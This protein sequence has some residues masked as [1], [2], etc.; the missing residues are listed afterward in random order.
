MVIEQ[1]IRVPGEARFSAAQRGVV[2]LDN[3]GIATGMELIF[4]SNETG[5]LAAAT[6]FREALDVIIAVASDR[7]ADQ[8]ARFDFEE[9]Q[10]AL[11]T[12]ERVLELGESAE[13]VR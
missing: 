12:Q 10:R 5:A 11:A 7:L 2:F 3:F 1:S 8:K 9:H 6:R 13:A 4:G